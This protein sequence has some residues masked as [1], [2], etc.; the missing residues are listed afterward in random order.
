MR[1]FV[2]GT[3]RCGSSTFYQA[4]KTITNYTC[5][6]ETFAGQVHNFEYLDNHIEVAV[7]NVQALAL[8]QNKYPNNMIVQLIRE[9]KGCIQSLFE[10][11]PEYL[12]AWSF[13]VYLTTE[14]TEKVAE[15][16]YHCVNQH[17]AKIPNLV[18]V[19]VDDLEWFW[20][21]FIQSIG[22]ECDMEQAQKIL[23][24]KYNP[25]SKRGR[26]NYVEN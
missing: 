21:R 20:A 6:H 11:C 9:P 16:Y 8:L 22:A 4:C 5:G 15:A 17:I 24:R 12:K 13:Q 2:V 1:I 18:T 26:D 3:G 25:G 19:R 23:S 10:Q 14:V 7:Q